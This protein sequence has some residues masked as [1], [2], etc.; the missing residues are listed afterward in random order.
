[1][2]IKR[3]IEIL[4]ILKK[5]FGENLTEPVIKTCISFCNYWNEFEELISQHK[6][7][8]NPDVKRLA[9]AREINLFEKTRIFT[10]LNAVLLV[11][12]LIVLFFNWKISLILLG[13]LILNYFFIKSQKRKLVQNEINIFNSTMINQKN[14]TDRFIEIIKYYCTGGI[15]LISEKGTAFLP[16]LPETC[17]TGIETYPHHKYDEEKKIPMSRI[18]NP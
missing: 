12:S 6:I 9:Q 7:R 3:N 17:V 16:L 18:C 10:F 4:E 13:L 5:N 8:T 1:M 11:I 15:Q 14:D 2:D